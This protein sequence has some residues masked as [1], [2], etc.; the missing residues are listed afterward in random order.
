MTNNS[1]KVFL[2]FVISLFFLNS[3]NVFCQRSKLGIEV[4]K[5]TCYIASKHFAELKFKM[6]DPA[7]TDS[8]F[9]EALII[10]HN[11]NTE[12]LF[13]LIFAVLPYNKVPIKIPLLPIVLKYPLISAGDSLYNLKNK[14]LPKYLFFTSPKDN[15]GDKDKLAHFFGAAFL[16]YSGNIFDLSD[17]IGYFVE[18]FEQDFVVQSSIDPRDLHADTL[19]DIFGRLLKKNKEVLPSQVMLMKTLFYCRY[20]LP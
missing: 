11:N 4:D 2:S 12:A 5:L 9:K 16:S 1:T 8:I 15:F 3:C 6:D 19:G 14:N 17:L 7:R 18:V 10:T 20:N 13:A